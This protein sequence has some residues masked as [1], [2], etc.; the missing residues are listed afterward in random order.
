MAKKVGRKSKYQ[1]IKDNFDYIDKQLNNGASEKQIAKTL[2]I[3]YSTWN[4][5]K[6]EYQEFKELCSKSRVELV[7][8]L[9]SA[10]VKKA[11]GFSRIIERP[12]KVKRVEYVDGKKS[13]EWEEVI[14]YNDE[15]YFPPET[16]AIFG[17]LNIY[18]EEYVK[19]K[20][21]YELK[22]REV[23]LKE[24]EAKKNSW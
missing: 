12:M 23:K 7:E 24:E 5:Y 6:E 3:A 2:G 17:A 11:M 20:K 14:Y 21:A 18:D 13:K 4:K 9:R 16:T 19:D 22:E 8:D 1:V 10:L 15:T